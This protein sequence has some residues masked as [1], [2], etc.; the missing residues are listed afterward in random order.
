MYH[1]NNIKLNS[2]I[3]LPTNKHKTLT[4]LNDS[5]G[6]PTTVKPEKRLANLCSKCA[7]YVRT[8]HVYIFII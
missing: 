8:Y 2:D 5:L 4:L 1:H 6:I 3:I 7:Y